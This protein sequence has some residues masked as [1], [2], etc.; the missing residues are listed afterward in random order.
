MRLRLR[1]MTA[2]LAVGI[3]VAVAL[4][5]AAGTYLYSIHHFKTMLDTAREAA[6]AQGRLMRVAL[7]HQMMEKDRTLIERMTRSFGQ[8]AGIENV[9]ILDREGRIRYTNAPPGTETDI[10]IESPTC[11]ACHR[12]PPD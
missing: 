11:Q 12:L 10:G 3:T 7:E 9:M 1:G 5:S 2:G 4:A 6:L 8:E